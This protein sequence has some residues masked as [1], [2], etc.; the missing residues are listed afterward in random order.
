[1]HSAI[2][3]DGVRLY[4]GGRTSARRIG[5]RR[6][7]RCRVDRA[8]AARVRAA[9]LRARDR[10]RQG[11]YVRSLVADIAAD[12]GTVAHMGRPAP[13]ARRRVR[14]R[15]GAD[16]RPGDAGRRRWALDRGRAAERL[17]RGRGRRRRARPARAPRGAQ[18]A[19]ERGSA[20]RA[21]PR[22]QLVDAAG[23]S[24][25]HRARAEGGEVGGGGGGGK[26]KKK[27]KKTDPAPKVIPMIGESSRSSTGLHRPL[28]AGWQI[29]QSPRRPRHSFISDAAVGD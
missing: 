29:P 25:R 19:P 18:I 5:S 22:F 16:A 7:P 2:K 24:A 28:D 11:T 4:K 12:L 20:S 3:V 15:A 17:A 6:A 10:V 23:P 26:K 13:H 27:K 1:M 14:H 21:A 9:A 8:R